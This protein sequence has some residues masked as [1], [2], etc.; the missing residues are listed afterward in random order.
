MAQHQQTS[1]ARAPA[2][3]VSAKTVTALVALAIALTFIVQNRQ[4]VQ[5]S[6]FLT[7][8]STPLWVALAVVL[9]LGMLCGFLAFRF[10]K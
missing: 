8:V 5:I 7:S 2:R 4:T 1:G 6:L 3:R 9:I 10:K